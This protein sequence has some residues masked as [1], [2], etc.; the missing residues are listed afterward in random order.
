MSP[1][2]FSTHPS[3]LLGEYGIQ[4]AFEQLAG[5]GEVL[6]G[7]GD[8]RADPLER[9]IENGDNA[10]LFGKRGNGIGSALMLSVI[11]RCTA[12]RLCTR[13]RCRLRRFEEIM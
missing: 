5:V 9:F 2:V 8:R 11:S 7:I 3:S 1:S 6:L 12:L 13:F 4:V 10:L